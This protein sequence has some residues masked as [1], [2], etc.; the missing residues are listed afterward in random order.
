M[1]LIHYKICIIVLFFIR[2]YC[3]LIQQMLE[4]VFGARGQAM[5][6]VILLAIN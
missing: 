4:K 6:H 2:V 1:Y 3:F 5:A